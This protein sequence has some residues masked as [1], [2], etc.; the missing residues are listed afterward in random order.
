MK[1]FF[2]SRDL[3]LSY[4]V[5]PQLAVRLVLLQFVPLQKSKHTVLL[6]YYSCLTWSVFSYKAYKP[7][8]IYAYSL[9]YLFICL[10]VH[11]LY[12]FNCLFINSLFIYSH[13]MLKS[14][15]K[16]PASNISNFQDGFGWTNGAI[17]DLLVTYNHR[18]NV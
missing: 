5:C 13:K 8:Y 4:K 16:S 1:F 6:I 17:L 12:L 9:I 11:S 10:F 7:T 2:D 14:F 3:I 18:L 15:Y